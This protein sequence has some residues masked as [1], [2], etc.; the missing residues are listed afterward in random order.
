MDGYSLPSSWPLL[1]KQVAKTS[2]LLKIKKYLFSGILSREK[3][4]DVIYL[5]H[6]CEAI[7]K[8]SNTLGIFV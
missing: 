8:S 1:E 4:T 2:G 7:T 5:P 6:G 3:H